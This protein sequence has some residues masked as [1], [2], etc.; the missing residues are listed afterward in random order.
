MQAYT[1]Q[2]LTSRAKSAAV[3]RYASDPPVLDWQD[4]HGRN[5]GIITPALVAMGWLYTEH[6]ERIA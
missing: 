4:A 6:G 1:F 2:Q 5:Y 3:A